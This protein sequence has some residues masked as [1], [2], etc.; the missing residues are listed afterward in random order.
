MAR[1]ETT[2]DSAMERAAEIVARLDAFSLSVERPVFGEEEES[3]SCSVALILTGPTG[4][5]LRLGEV[6]AEPAA[7][8]DAD[9]TFRVFATGADI[10]FDDS[11]DVS[12]PFLDIAQAAHSLWAWNTPGVPKRSS[13]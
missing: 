6:F 11:D 10:E 2:R 7:D 13:R 8:D 5:L 4:A 9:V 3:P 12:A 1:Y